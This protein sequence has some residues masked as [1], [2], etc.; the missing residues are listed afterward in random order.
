MGTKDQ[1]HRYAADLHIS[2]TNADGELS[3]RSPTTQNGRPD[4]VS[5]ILITDLRFLNISA[6]IYG[7]CVLLVFNSAP[8]ARLR[9]DYTPHHIAI[10][11]VCSNNSS[12]YTNITKY[13]ARFFSA[14]A[15]L[16]IFLVQVFVGFVCK[17]A[18]R[19]IEQLENEK[20]EE[21]NCYV[22]RGKSW[23]TN[24]VDSLHSFATVGRSLRESDA[25]LGPCARFAYSAHRICISAFPSSILLQASS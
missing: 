22:Q 23:A 25:T 20:C 7:I 11:F 2:W 18:K 24:T 16:I 14:F 5:S 1:R 15:F 3:D 6:E 4:R 19:R 8:A 17:P 10:A 9:L 13:R 12:V 21:C